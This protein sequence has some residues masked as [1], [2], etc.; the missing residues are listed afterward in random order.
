MNQICSV[1]KTPLLL[2]E[3]PKQDLLTG[4]IEF[5]LKARCPFKAEQMDR[6]TE[7]PVAIKKVTEG[8]GIGGNDH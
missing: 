6:H 7:L 1:C 8:P 2:T 3:V 5:V 4:R